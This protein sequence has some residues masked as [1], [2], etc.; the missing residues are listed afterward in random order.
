MNTGCTPIVLAIRGN[1]P[2]VVRELLS[3]GAIVPPPGITNDPA[4]LSLLYPQPMYGHGH[5][6][7][8]Q[9]MNHPQ[10]MAM[11]PEFYPQQ[12]YDPRQQQQQQVLQANLPPAEVAKTIP[13]RNYPNCKYGSSCVFLH[14]RAP[15]YPPTGPGFGYEGFQSFQPMPYFN[16]Q[17]NGFQPQQQPQHEGDSQSQSQPQPQFQQSD[18]PPQDDNSQQQQPQFDQHSLSG[19][20]APFVPFGMTSPP[21]AQFGLSPMSPPMMPPMPMSPHD[22]AAFFAQSPPNGMMPPPPSSGFNPRRLSVNGNGNG[23]QKPFHG[24]KPS[25]SGGPRPWAPG[26]RSTAGWKD[27]TPPPCAFFAQSKCRNGEFCKFPHLDQEGNDV[28]H[29]DVVR[30]VL[31]PAPSVAR[32]PKPVRASMGG[33]GFDPSRQFV[34]RGMNEEQST[35]VEAIPESAPIQTESSAPVTEAPSTTEAQEAVDQVEPSK[36]A[37]PVQVNGNGSAN[38][39]SIARSASQPGV[40]RFQHQQQNGFHSRAQSPAFHANGNTNGHANGNGNGPRRGGRPFPNGNPAVQQGARSVSAGGG[41]NKQ[42]IPNADEFPALGGMSGNTS[43]Q[44]KSVSAFSKTAAQVLSAPAPPKPE[45]VKPESEDV[46][47][48]FHLCVKANRKGGNDGRRIRFRCCYHY[49]EQTRFHSHY[50]RKG[51]CS[52]DP[53]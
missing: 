3:A 30:G 43:P 39:A 18:M 21:P 41:G 23:F 13:C 42:R 33:F 44:E 51:S 46:C 38:N 47:S 17:A 4:M 31:A 28:R 5:G 34:P 15:F 25:F 50:H 20:P 19:A 35:S 40:Q 29:P 16:P 49:N 7:P 10:H 26:A 36:S 14:P 1:F 22:A 27:G 53:R 24:K 11:A 8:P 48:P 45:V 37:Q 6:L 52:R 32:F 2:D 9:F 12:F